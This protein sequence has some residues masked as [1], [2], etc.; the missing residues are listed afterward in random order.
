MVAARMEKD[1]TPSTKIEKGKTPNVNQV[2]LSLLEEIMIRGQE[3]APRVKA[4]KE[5][6]GY[7]TKISMRSPV[8]TVA[9]R[10]L[11]Y[12][13]AAAEA[14]WILSGDNR[15][16][17]IAPY[18]SHIS[19]FSDDGLRF[20]GAYGV[21]VVDQLPYV[22]E[23]L[24]KDPDTRQAVINI[25][26]ES[27]RPS[28]DIP[29][30][31]SLQWLIRDG[32]L[33]CLDTMRSSDAWLGWPYDVIN[34]SLISAYIRLVLKTR[35]G[36]EVG[37][38]DLTLTAGSQHLYADNWP[39]VQKIL[40]GDDLALPTPDLQVALENIPLIA[41]NTENLVSCLWHMANHGGLLDGMSL[42]E[43]GL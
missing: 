7:Q 14:A 15:V 30:T 31:L 39:A 40:A 37:L 32:S 22:C 34:M 4:I 11:G 33:H 18:A 35:Y 3:C 38:G 1:K 5:L 36:V 19:Q 13:F 26:R 21:K 29:C 41:L 8:V 25:W 2:W 27:P 24:A 23:A 20:F 17:T 42:A 43:K 16:S 6:L 10:R 9:A 28:K 12:R